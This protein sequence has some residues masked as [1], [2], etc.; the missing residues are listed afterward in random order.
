MDESMTVLLV[1]DPGLPRNVL[2]KAM[3]EW[4]CRVV[5]AESKEALWDILKGGLSPQLIFMDWFSSLLDCN[6]FCRLAKNLTY[7]DGVYLV[8]GVPRSGSSTIRNAM[9]AGADD[10]VYQPY[11][12]DEVRVRLDIAARMIH[13]Q[14]KQVVDN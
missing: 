11:D 12:L 8:V 3:S 5:T 1:E 14:K 13:Y 2:V 9:M 6:E 4:G 7:L 10:F